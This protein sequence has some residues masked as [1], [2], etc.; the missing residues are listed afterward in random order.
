[1]IIEIC[2][3]TP[4][5][6]VFFLNISPY[7]PRATTPSWILAPPESKMPMIGT[8]V[9]IARSIILMILFPAASPSDPP[10]T[11]KSWE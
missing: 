7:L 2:G 4:D 5:A 9:E 10:K 3:M 11:V 1:M 8:P 6:M